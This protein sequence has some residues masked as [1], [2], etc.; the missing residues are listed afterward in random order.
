[1]FPDTAEE[2]A[3][4]QDSLPT[5]TAVERAQGGWR[6]GSVTRWPRGAITWLRDALEPH[7]PL[8]VVQ[9]FSSLTCR[10][11]QPRP[12]GGRVLVPPL[13]ALSS[14]TR[15]ERR[16]QLV[17]DGGGAGPAPESSDGRNVRECVHPNLCPK[18]FPTQSLDNL[19]AREGDA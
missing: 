5:F 1:M 11:S 10:V 9:G 3:G 16:S 12:P 4:A 13:K 14:P 2:E 6:R 15:L 18:Q 19:R 7:L 17:A 8:F